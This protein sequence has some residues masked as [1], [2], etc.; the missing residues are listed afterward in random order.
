MGEAKIHPK[1]P[2]RCRTTLWDVL[3]VLVKRM[4]RPSP[5]TSDL[6]WLAVALTFLCLPPVTIVKVDVVVSV[7]VCR[8]VG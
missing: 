1:A 7:L 6:L 5:R 2:A 8:H 3:I 4:R